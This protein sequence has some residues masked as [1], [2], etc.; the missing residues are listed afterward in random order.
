MKIAIQGLGEVP[1]PV[2]L[3]LEEEKPDKSYVIASD[4]QLDYV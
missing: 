2:K 1:N 4:Y 3:V